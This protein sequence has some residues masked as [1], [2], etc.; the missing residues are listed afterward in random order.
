MLEVVKAIVHLFRGIESAEYCNF[1]YQKQVFF[2]AQVR[3]YLEEGNNAPLLGRSSTLSAIEALATSKRRRVAVLD[4]FDMRKQRVKGILTESMVVSELRQRIDL[5][6]PALR[7]KRV[8]DLECVKA[9]SSQ[10][11]PLHVVYNTMT[12]LQAFTIMAEQNITSLPVL[13]ADGNIVSV[14]SA[15]DI[16]VVGA[17]G[18]DFQSL[19][20]TVDQFKKLALKKFPCL[21]PKS[22]LE[23]K[24][25]PDLPVCVALDDTFEDVVAK[26]EDGNIHHVYVVDQS[27]KQQQQQQQQQQWWR[28][29][30]VPPVAIVS[31]TDIIR[32][33][34]EHYTAARV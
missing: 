15:R 6:Q 27:W 18:D 9:L 17:G 19:Y 29:R 5:V 31:Q 11:K 3:D 34:F 2:S 23:F 32:E 30:R 25:V 13:N 26:F 21:Y 10:L 22:R 8:R 7:H 1:E 33:I 28:P 4:S 14:I 16:R 24:S 12:A 20:L